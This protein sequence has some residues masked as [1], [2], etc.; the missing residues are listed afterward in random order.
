MISWRL[1]FF[2]PFVLA[3]GPLCPKWSQNAAGGAT[4][5]LIVNPC[6][7]RYRASTD[8]IEQHIQRYK[9]TLGR[10][11]PFIP[12]LA[13]YS[14]I[15]SS[16][17]SQF[18]L[19]DHLRR[20]LLTIHSPFIMVD[21]RMESHG[22]LDTLAVS[23]FCPK[24]WDLLRTAPDQ[25]EDRERAD[26]ARLKG[27]Q[28]VYFKMKRTEELIFGWPI[29]LSQAMT[30]RE[31]MKGANIHYER[32][33]I[34]DHQKPRDT[35]VEQL[36]D[37]FKKYPDNWM[38]F[39]CK[40]GKGRTTTAMIMRDMWLNAQKVSAADIIMRNSIFAAVD[41]L[42][43]EKLRDTYRLPFAQERMIFLHAFYK[44][45]LSKQ[46]SWLHFIQT[47]LQLLAQKYAKPFN[48]LIPSKP[49]DKSQSIHFKVRYRK[50]RMVR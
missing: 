1:A 35:E 12:S 38:H 34:P 21:L 13:G 9:A 5:E 6:G 19:G 27:P 17:S 40:A 14:A 37:L 36:L 44:F 7:R 29:L 22:F 30:E 49:I 42:D 48:P 25:V 4:R 18:C 11:P 24:N 32:I 39:H 41:L 31:A 8:T 3:G 33:P 10:M 2:L 46:T 45:C 15:K 20:L 43:L 16:G 26:F 23:F 28:R 47:N 50:R